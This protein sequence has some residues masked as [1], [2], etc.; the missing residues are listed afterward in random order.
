[1]RV[2]DIDIERQVLVV[3]QGKGAKDRVIPLSKNTCNKLS[4]YVKDR[5][6][7]SSLFGL[8]AA[9]ISGKIRTFATKAR[10]DIHTHSLRDYFATTLSEKG[11][12]I[13]EIQSLLG[14]A[15]LTHTERYTL[16]T[17]KHLK[18]AIELIDKEPEEKIASSENVAREP[19]QP[20]ILIIKVIE[21]KAWTD[22]DKVLRSDYFLHFLIRNEGQTPV[23]EIEI[24]LLDADNKLLEINKESV[25][26]VKEDFVFKPMVKLAEGSYRISCKYKA[27]DSGQLL[28][29]ILP[30]EV[31]RASKEGEVY[32]IPNELEFKFEIYK[33]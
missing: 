33:R 10:V 22:Y 9:S 11:A 17:D 2:G 23:V 6:K 12:T 20:P 28:E 32:V 18:D 3:R 31:K 25:L 30:F 4:D 26:G 14:H 27:V 21:K 13:R 29:V 24:S 7:D 8:A 1:M 5:E 19:Q 15:N 16:H